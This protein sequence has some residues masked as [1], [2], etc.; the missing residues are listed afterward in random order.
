M[1]ILSLSVS[2][3]TEP[4]NNVCYPERKLTSLAGCEDWL[5]RSA[6]YV[7]RDLSDWKLKK[8][9]Q[10]LLFFEFV[11]KFLC[12]KIELKLTTDISHKAHIEKFGNDDNKPVSPIVSGFTRYSSTTISNNRFV[13]HKNINV[14][15]E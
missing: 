9:S 12:K 15:I 4:T 8:H 1:V 11:S 5:E 2:S 10:P 7:E 6:F 13:Q 3:S 14:N